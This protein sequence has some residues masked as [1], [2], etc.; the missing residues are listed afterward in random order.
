[1]LELRFGLIDGEHR[2][3]LEVAKMLKVTKENARQIETKALAKL[4]LF[5]NRRI[6]GLNVAKSMEPLMR[7]C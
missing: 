3:L 2:S 7:W 6:P 4:R 5:S 1:L